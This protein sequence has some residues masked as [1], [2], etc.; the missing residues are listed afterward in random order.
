[1]GYA[2]VFPDV[3]VVQMLY[4]NIPLRLKWALIELALV[5]GILQP[6]KHLFNR[7]TDCEVGHTF[8]TSDISLK[9]TVLGLNKDIQ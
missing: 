2:R 1:L 4:W 9:K 6:S 5:L 7:A 3:S 8:S